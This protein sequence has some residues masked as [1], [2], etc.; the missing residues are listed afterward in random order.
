VF[1]PLRADPL[2]RLTGVFDFAEW[3]PVNG[4]PTSDHRLVWVDVQIPGRGGS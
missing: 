1:W 3:G 4:F 2:S